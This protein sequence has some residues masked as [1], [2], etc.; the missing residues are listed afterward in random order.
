MFPHLKHTSWCFNPFPNTSRPRLSGDFTPSKKSNHQSSGNH[1]PICSDRN[2]WNIHETA[3]QFWWHL[4]SPYRSLLNSTLTRGENTNTTEFWKR[5]PQSLVVLKTM[6]VKSLSGIYYDI[7]SDILSMTYWMLSGIL[8][9]ILSG[10]CSGPGVAHSIRSWWDGVRVQTWRTASGAGDME[11]GSRHGPQDAE[12][13]TWLGKTRLTSGGAGVGARGRGWR[14][15]RRR[16]HT[17]VNI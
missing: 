14:R 16:S 8:Y 2:Y 11:F 12:P 5:M 4:T 1:D 9:G 3:S 10:M 7:L 15:R 13:A 6:F 17:F